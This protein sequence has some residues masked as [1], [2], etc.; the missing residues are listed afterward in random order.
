VEF[1]IPEEA[2]I[3][4]RRPPGRELVGRGCQC[5]VD[6]VERLVHD[7][8]NVRHV[9]VRVV[10]DVPPAPV[11]RSGLGPAGADALKSVEFSPPAA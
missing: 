6:G 5:L 3:E 9:V 10:D 8:P 1:L 11:R 7:E 4:L 2:A